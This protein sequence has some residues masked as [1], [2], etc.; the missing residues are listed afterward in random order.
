VKIEYGFLFLGEIP[1]IL[2]GVCI[3]GLV[4]IMTG[5][6]ERYILIYLGYLYKRIYKGVY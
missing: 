4:V 5:R 1:G 3:N 6:L 2:S